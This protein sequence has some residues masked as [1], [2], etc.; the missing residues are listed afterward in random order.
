L[1]INAK[2]VLNKPGSYEL[3]NSPESVDFTFILFAVVV[4]SDSSS[5][6]A[7]I[8]VLFDERTKISNEK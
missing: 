4:F 3:L 1:Q 6:V 2:L 7:R 8:V 5:V